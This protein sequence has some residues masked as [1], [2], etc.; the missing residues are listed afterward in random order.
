VGV[1][2]AV[3]LSVCE[4]VVGGGVVVGAREMRAGVDGGRTGGRVG[5]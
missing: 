3:L 5:V 2:D 1:A 4:C